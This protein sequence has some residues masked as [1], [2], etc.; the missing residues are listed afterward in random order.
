M[1]DALA[2]FYKD[3][4]VSAS[5]AGVLVTGILDQQTP[6][7]FGLVSSSS[8][9]LRVPVTV[10]AAVGDVV[11]VNGSTWTVAAIHLAHGVATEKLLDL[12]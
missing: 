12:K 3:F 1:F 8:V 6:D 5:V 11:I 2:P 4:G 10:A 7:S 9:S